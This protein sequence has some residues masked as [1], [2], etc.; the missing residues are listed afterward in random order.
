VKVY[1]T[2]LQGEIKIT[3]D[4]S[5]FQIETQKTATA[6]EIVIGRVSKDSPRSPPTT[7]TPA[8]SAQAV[9]PAQSSETL[10]AGAIIGNKNSKKYHL[11]GCPGYTQTLEKNRVYFKSAEEAEAAG[12]T[13]A[14]NCK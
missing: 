5:T 10:A 13:K 4:G 1:R 11:P 2:D 7:P 9:K 3:S 6:A 8:T 12:Y 14:G